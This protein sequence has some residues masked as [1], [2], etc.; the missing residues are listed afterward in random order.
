M[1]ITAVLYFL[2]VWVM[3]SH[4]PAR[5]D[6]APVDAPLAQLDL[7]TQAGIDAVQGA[8]R[9]K[10]IELIPTQHRRPDAQGQPTGAPAVTWDYAPHAGARDFDDADWEKIDP[11]TLALRRGHGRI[12][13]NWYR[14]TI[15]VPEQ[16]DG[17][18]L[19]GTT[20]CF[21]TSLDDYAEV[22][23]DGELPR[24]TGQNGGSVVAG[25]NATN[26]L[27]IGRNV[28]PG[29]KIQLA[30]FGINGPISD[31]PT[32]FIWMRLAKLSFEKG[33]QVP[34]AVPAQEVNVRVVRLDPALDAIVPANPKIFKLAEGFQFTEGPVWSREGGYLLFSDPNANRIYAYAP[35]AGTLSLFRPNSGYEGTDVAEYGQPG[36]NGLTFDRD[37]RLTI[38]QHGNH[39]VVRVED[40]G[41]LTVLADRY[42]GKRLNSPN[43]LVYKSDGAVYF[44]DPP[45]GLPKFYDDPRKE[46]PYSG[47]YRSSGGKVTL[48]TRELKGPNGI[49]FS[50]D[51][52]YLYIGNWDPA[53]KVVL[54]FPVKRDGTLGA[55]TVFADLTHEV[56]GEE[57]LDGIK[58]DK[59]GNLY[60]SAPDGLRIYSSAGKHLGTVIAPRPIHN[61]AWGGD[62][63]RTLYLTARDRLYRIALLV[64][65]VRP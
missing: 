59:L 44:T 4:V 19:A 6:D 21:E 34:L 42:D 30:V 37:G 61:F 47:V 10:D 51:E 46:L 31:P 2:F 39:R 33:P 25:W 48:L 13:F 32:N 23:V 65:G 60:L 1:R 49:A 7:T 29:Q 9:Y 58:V 43:D 12:S 24:L 28:K 50:P 40:D 36:S 63:G 14:L 27:V 53:A 22:W 52:K 41:Q 18:A 17:V 57:A 15:T 64:E 3:T 54:R 11:A 62:D 16:I 56:P 5:A 55:S 26:R 8:W 45:F 35:K 38:D 20:A